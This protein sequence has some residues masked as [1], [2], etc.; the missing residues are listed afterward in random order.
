MA[1][2]IIRVLRVLEYVGPRSIVEAHLKTVVHGVRR[3]GITADVIEVGK[4][5]RMI[6]PNLGP[7]PRHPD[8][9]SGLVCPTDHSKYVGK[10]PTCHTKLPGIPKP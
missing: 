5:E 3:I 8:F 7:D 6:N 10:C 1:E 4:I 2:D 9:A